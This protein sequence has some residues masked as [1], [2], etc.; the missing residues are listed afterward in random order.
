[1][2]KPNLVIAVDSLV[3]S[4]ENHLAKSIQISNT[5]LSPGG[6]VGNNRK[7]IS[8]NVLGVKVVAIGVPLVVNLS[9]L[10]KTTDDLIV[11]PK[12]VEQKVGELSKIISKSIN[13]A[14]NH[15]TEKELLELTL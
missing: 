7:E 13:L 11:T 14:F 1:M 6:G 8:E 4:D 2:L 3:T 12:D 10:C 15:L 9:S 5:K